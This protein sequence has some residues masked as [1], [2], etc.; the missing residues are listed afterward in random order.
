MGIFL[1]STLRDL[2]GMIIYE[3]FYITS[4]ECCVRSL[5]T[6]IYKCR[7]QTTKTPL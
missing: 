7:K 2:E 3:D 1:Y 4:S 6:Y 5:A